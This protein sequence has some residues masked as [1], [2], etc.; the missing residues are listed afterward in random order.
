[1]RVLLDSHTVLWATLADERL[2]SAVAA[3]IEDRS[4]LVTISV[5]TTWELTTKALA[6][7]LTLPEP[8]ETYFDGLVRDFGYELLPNHQRHVAALPE[9]PAIHADPFDRMLVAQALVE[10]LDLVSGDDRIRRFPVRTIW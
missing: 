8:P 6:G 7:R 1:M 5:A 2:P 10:D 9:L 3:L 4:N